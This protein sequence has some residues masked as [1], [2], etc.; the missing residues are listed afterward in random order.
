MWI[1]KYHDWRKALSSS[2]SNISTLDDMIC[3]WKENRRESIIC[4]FQF[5]KNS[6]RTLDKGLN[7]FGL[8]FFINRIFLLISSIHESFTILEAIEIKVHS[9]LNRRWQCCWRKG[10]DLNPSIFRWNATSHLY[11]DKIST[12]AN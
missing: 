10:L 12:V 8:S 1:S 11:F 6:C 5:G 4:E 3:W 9:T 2:W 7:P